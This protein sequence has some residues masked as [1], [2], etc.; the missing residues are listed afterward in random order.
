[1]LKINF[2]SSDVLFSASNKTQHKMQDMKK[3]QIEMIE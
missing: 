3:P 1:M 2:R